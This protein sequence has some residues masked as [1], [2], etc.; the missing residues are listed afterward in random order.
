MDLFLQKATRE[1]SRKAYDDAVRGSGI[2]QLSQFGDGALPFDVVVPG[3][4]RGTLRLHEG[5]LFIETEEPLTLC[6]GCD[7]DNVRDLARLL[8][9]TFGDKRRAGRKSRRADFDAGRRVH[10]RLSRNR[11]GLHGSHAKDERRAARK[12]H[13]TADVA[14]AAIAL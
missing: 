13:R 6:T 4:G 10:F 12:R 3:R 2:Y 5:S 11:V 7:C 1:Y 14:D 8:E 9:E